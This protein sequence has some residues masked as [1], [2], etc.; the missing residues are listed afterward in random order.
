M[1][2]FYGATRERKRHGRIERDILRGADPPFARHRAKPMLTS[3]AIRSKLKAELEHKHPEARKRIMRRKLTKLDRALS[4]AEARYVDIHFTGWLVC[5]G[6][7]AG[8][9]LSERIDKPHNST[10]PLTQRELEAVTRY[11]RANA[12][13]DAMSAYV[14]E[15][16]FLVLAPWNEGAWK[17]GGAAIPQIKLAAQALKN[18]YENE[19]RT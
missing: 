3:Y 16:L 15:V 1:P 17:L 12:R 4:D 9:S 10:G 19:K 7:T 18:V 14:L 8:S 5:E 2:E 11:R 6:K 13:L